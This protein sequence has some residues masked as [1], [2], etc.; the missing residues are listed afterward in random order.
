MNA[1]PHSAKPKW[2]TPVALA[3]AVFGALTLYSGG[4]ALFGGEAARAAVGNAVPFVLWFN[5][6]SGFAY[7]AAAAGLWLWR[8]WA[9]NAAWFLALTTLAVFAEFGLTVLNGTPFEMRTVGAMALRAGFWLGI[10]FAVSRSAKST[11]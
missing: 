11:A 1:M 9:G 4:I 7:I 3:A 2:A 6:I 8:S 5:F 10:A